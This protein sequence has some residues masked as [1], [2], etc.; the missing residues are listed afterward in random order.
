M[1]AAPESELLFSVG[2]PGNASMLVFV[3]QPALAV[4][5]RS[6][7]AA[8]LGVNDAS[9]VQLVALISQST[10][11]VLYP[12]R[13]M[14]A[15]L[16]RR[17]SSAADTEVAAARAFGARKL[18][19]ATGITAIC[20]IFVDHPAVKA[21]YGGSSTT[22]VAAAL[23]S[24]TRVAFS[25]A[26]ATAAAYGPFRAAFA[27]ATG[28]TAGSLTITLVNVRSTPAVGTSGAR[29][30]RADSTT[31]I[32]A[33]ACVG[34][35]VGVAVCGVL[36]TRRLSAGGAAK[37]QSEVY[38]ATPQFALMNPMSSKGSAER[39][40]GSRGGIP[41][42]PPASRMWDAG[43]PSAPPG[44][45]GAVS[46]G[47]PAGR[48]S[49]ARQLVDVSH[50]PCIPWS[51]LRPSTFPDG[52]LTM[53]GGMSIILWAKWVRPT[54][55]AVV[56]VV[57]KVSRHVEVLRVRP[58]D[59]D[60]AAL[61]A[62]NTRIRE[63]AAIT[64][65]AAKL[66]P[67]AGDHFVH[68]YGTTGGQMPEE[69]TSALHVGAHVMSEEVVGIVLR[70]ER[71][72]SLDSKLHGNIAWS[73]G[74]TDRLRLLCSIS[75]GLALLHNGRALLTDGLDGVLYH[76]DIKPENVLIVDDPVRGVTGRLC[77]FGLA[78]LR[79]PAGFG[80]SSTM[81]GGMA[82]GTWQYEAPEM[83]EGATP[84]RRTDVYAFGT[85]MW[86]VLTGDKP[87]LNTASKFER[88]AALL[89]PGSVGLEMNHAKMA[90]V[91]P[92]LKSLLRACLSSDRNAR[93]S[94]NAVCSVLTGELNF[95]RAL[96]S[97]HESRDDFDV[98]LS[99]SW[100][101]S[102]ARSTLARQPQ[103]VSALLGACSGSAGLGAVE[104]RPRLPGWRQPLAHAVRHYLSKEGLRVWMD[105]NNMGHKLDRSMHRGIASS[106][107]VVALI[108][109]D[110]ERSESCMYE[111]RKA[112]K[113]GKTVIVALVEPQ[114]GGHHFGQTWCKKGTELSKLA[115]VRRETAEAEQYDMYADLTGAAEEDWGGDVGEVGCRKLTHTA[116]AL[117]CILRLLREYG[118]VGRRP[119]D[120]IN[121]AGT[122]DGLA[123]D[124]TGV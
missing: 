76:G 29:E 21:A 12:G 35:L 31:I 81:G 55:G 62:Q 30:T 24:V 40:T 82:G 77:D 109:P 38:A 64:M 20:S 46:A 113:L 13:E 98:F 103:C 83:Y 66:S 93:P 85:L 111:L 37:A 59:K 50:L 27:A 79:K 11:Q 84:S 116:T 78:G 123:S 39:A 56:E 5:L 74:L 70:F 112:R 43:D 23:A 52:C 108:S 57:V 47:R 120:P 32:V 90:E 33:G 86:E 117:P 7:T 122:D 61:E 88:Q 17:H 105:C 14:N 124:G 26:A 75:D 102:S 97:V 65:H 91:S 72:S 49:T 3:Q 28:Q 94:I 60:R 80:G 92:Q 44:S 16:L 99:Y 6:S 73:A 100:G 101:V 53:R 58:S 9:A 4:G 19:G 63:E 104:A 54:T 22:A 42:A 106:R 96:A 2:I 118:V 36:Y 110:Y 107:V 45:S 89:R 48:P 15:R 68:C 10:G 87:W 18:Q 71:G 1:P 119:D 8:L 121:H 95:L 67:R 115:H 51:E 34:A 25:D 69:W 41:S 114:S